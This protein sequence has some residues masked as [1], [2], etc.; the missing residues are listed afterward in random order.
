MILK[1]QVVGMALEPVGIGQLHHL[2]KRL[3]I[4]AVILEKLMPH[5]GNPE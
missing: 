3:N 4:K 5:K 1:A 2:I